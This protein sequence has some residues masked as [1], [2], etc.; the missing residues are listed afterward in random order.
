[1][2]MLHFLISV[3]H[4]NASVHLQAQC[5]LPVTTP[6]KCRS[7]DCTDCLVRFGRGARNWSSDE[8]RLRRMATI[9]A[10]AAF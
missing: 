2:V 10:S 7:K 5:F 6:C 4:R 8:E 9:I 3:N 1:M